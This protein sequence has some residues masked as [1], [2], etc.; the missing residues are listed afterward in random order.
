MKAMGMEVGPDTLVVDCG[1][2]EVFMGRT[3]NMHMRSPRGTLEM[4]AI[5][6]SWFWLG[7]TKKQGLTEALRKVFQPAESDPES[8]TVMGALPTY[9]EQYDDVGPR[10]IKTMEELARR[11]LREDGGGTTEDILVVTHST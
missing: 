2:S 10:Y 9:P 1:L 3:L 4:T 5:S 11:K 8:I 6:E 7:A